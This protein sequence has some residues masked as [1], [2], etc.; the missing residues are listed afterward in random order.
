MKKVIVKTNDSLISQEYIQFLEHIKTDILQTQLKAATSITTELTMLYWRIGKH[1]SE[2]MAIESWGSKVIDNIAKD[3]KDSFPHLA[4][5]S[6]RN[7]RYM[8]K[9]AETY[10]EVNFAAAAAKLPWGHNMVLL[11]SLKNNEQ[12][13]WYIQQAID[14]GWSRSV[15]EM[16]IESD[17]YNRKGKAINNF[18]AVLPEIHSDL[19]EQTLKDP[20]NLNFLMMDEKARELEIEHG[21]MAHMQKFLVELGAGF[22]FAGRQYQ[23]KI[24]DDDC[25]ID[26]L[27]YN[28]ELHCFVVIELKAR[29]FDPRDVGQI[30]MYLSA[31]DNQLKKPE[32]RPTIGLILCKSKD[33]VRAKYALEHINRPIGISEYTTQMAKAFEAEIASKLP[34]I[35]DIE[36]ELARIDITDEIVKATI[37]KK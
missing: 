16:W 28:Y 9:F 37:L 24:G 29:K 22:A 10:A 6:L 5:F 20:Y 17:L 35:E 21:L 27:F 12:R 19:A 33:S 26:M 2:K 18:K 13:L 34:T 32:D 36:A 23:I 25:F 15:L 11:D 1:L 8:R 30:N 7:L 3:L 31:I 4:G 14:N